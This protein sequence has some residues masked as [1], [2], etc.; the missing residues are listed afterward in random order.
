MELENNLASS[1][2]V[3]F[4]KI[5]ENQYTL[6][7]EDVM[8]LLSELNE[9]STFSFKVDAQDLDS[10]LPHQILFKNE[11]QKVINNFQDSIK[12]Q[13][14]HI[15]DKK[16]ILKLKLASI[17]LIFKYL[18]PA[19]N[20]QLAEAEF[21]FLNYFNESEL[22]ESLVEFSESF[23]LSKEKNFVD[24]LSL[25]NDVLISFKFVSRRYFSKAEKFKSVNKKFFSDIENELS[26]F[27]K[28][29]DVNV[30]NNRAITLLSKRLGSLNENYYHDLEKFEDE[31]EENYFE[32][33]SPA[34]DHDIDDNFLW[35]GMSGEEAWDAYWNTQ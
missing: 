28:A 7:M 34:D 2:K 24:Y 21:Q 27:I 19:N 17:N 31:I 1:Y 35:G 23:I 8:F 13:N 33:D 5:Y 22:I 32:Y 12:N 30:I 6:L 3:F 16:E 26:S 15:I 20:S 11:S 29:I 14:F 4:Q 25:L 18:Y 9:N 10:L